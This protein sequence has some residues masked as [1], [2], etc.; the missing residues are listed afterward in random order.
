MET[1]AIGVSEEALP[2]Y[3]PAIVFAALQWQSISRCSRT[4]SLASA[5]KG[6]PVAVLASPTV[7]PPRSPPPSS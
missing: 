6:P 1:A 7:V 3:E 2:A 5:F 4:G